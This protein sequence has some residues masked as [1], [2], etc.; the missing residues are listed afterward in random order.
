MRK[1]RASASAHTFIE[2][3]FIMVEGVENRQQ[4]S[5]LYIHHVSFYAHF[6]FSDL[7]LLY[8]HSDEH[9]NSKYHT[10]A[11]LYQYSNCARANYMTYIL[12]ISCCNLSH[13]NC[14]RANYMTYILVFLVVKKTNK[15]NRFVFLI[16]CISTLYVDYQLKLYSN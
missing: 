1:A 5:N 11:S 4:Q 3:S 9:S 2:L 16:S 6:F 10:I 13:T 14:V 7:F 8:Q 12:C 15:G